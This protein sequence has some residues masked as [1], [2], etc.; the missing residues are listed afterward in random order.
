MLGSLFFTGSLST[1]LFLEYSLGLVILQAR[2]EHRQQATTGGMTRRKPMVKIYFENNYY[3]NSMPA[4]SNTLCMSFM[5]GNLFLDLDFTHQQGQFL[6][7]HKQIRWIV[8]QHMINDKNSIQFPFD[9][10]N[11]FRIAQRL[12]E[13][14]HTFFGKVWKSSENCLTSWDVFRNSCHNRTKISCIN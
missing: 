3:S 6:I 5:P 4:N 12:S 11:N 8:L 1:G 7:P 13:Q 2:V 14:L 10:W 9:T